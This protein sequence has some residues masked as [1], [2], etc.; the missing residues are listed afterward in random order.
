MMTFWIIYLIIYLIIGAFL[1]T[2]AYLLAFYNKEPAIV[3]ANLFTL[4]ICFIIV[5]L[6]SPLSPIFY[7]YYYHKKND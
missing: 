2:I 4:I 3:N 6:I 7:I 1:T 5:T